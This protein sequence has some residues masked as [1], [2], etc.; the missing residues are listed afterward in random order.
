MPKPMFVW[1]GTAWVS[2]ASEVE[3]L[4]NFA[5]QSYA[6]NQ[7]GMK[8]IVPSSV[9]VGSG[10]GSV[11]TSGA[12]SFSGVSSV[13]IN[14]CFSST[15]DN[16][17]IAFELDSTSGTGGTGIN[18]RLRVGGADNSSANYW[19]NRIF[20]QASSVTSSGPTSADTSFLSVSEYDNVG[21]STYM[22]DLF[23]PFRTAT[24][25][26]VGIGQFRYTSFY[27]HSQLKTGQTTVTTSYTGFTLLT[28]SGTM[29][30]RVKVYGYKN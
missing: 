22:Y 27:Q 15:Y 9:A 6:D 30:G 3:S 25:G 11:S 5:T 2:V 13:S 1:S 20:G 24:T 8:L 28:T 21:M 10:T 18:M 29:T 4:A 23:S 7:P 12:V 16:Y 17:K 14:D 19:N 26:L